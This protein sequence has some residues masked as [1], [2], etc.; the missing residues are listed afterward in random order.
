MPLLADNL[1]SHQPMCQQCLDLGLNFIFTALPDSHPALYE[2]LH[3]LDVFGAIS[4]LQTRQDHQGTSTIYHYR[5]TNLVPI[6]ETQPALL[7]NWCEL[8]LTHERTGQV[9]YHNAFITHHRLHDATVA[10]VVA[11]DRSRWKTEN[12]NHNVLQTKGYHLEHNFGH[13]QQHLSAC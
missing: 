4:T 7:V 6:R 3:G 11:A 8:T 1:Y 12:E 5:Y 10:S 13:G 9:L 2:R